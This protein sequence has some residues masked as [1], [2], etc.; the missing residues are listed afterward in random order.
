VLLVEHGVPF[1][2]H[3]RHDLEHAGPD[4]GIDQ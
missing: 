4:L 3:G 2:V 1:N